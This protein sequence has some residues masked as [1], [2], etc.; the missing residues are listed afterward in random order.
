MAARDAGS[1]RRRR[2]ST[3]VRV[4]MRVRVRVRWG[5]GAVRVRVWLAAA[6][7]AHHRMQLGQPA[8]NAAQPRRAELGARS[9]S[10]L[11]YRGLPTWVR[12]RVWVEVRV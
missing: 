12:V 6:P 5:E 10:H 1:L 4:K 8:L 11:V 2:L 3:W 7:S 9:P